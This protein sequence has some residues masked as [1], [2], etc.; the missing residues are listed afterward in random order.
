MENLITTKYSEGDSV[1]VVNPITGKAK[2][3]T[4]VGCVAKSLKGNTS[5]FYAFERDVIVDGKDVFWTHESKVFD[6]I[7]D[8]IE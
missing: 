4:I 1:Y 2:L 5:V 6:N 7:D 3:R 8:I